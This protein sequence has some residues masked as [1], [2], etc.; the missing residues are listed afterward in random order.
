MI[1]DHGR[2]ARKR[3]SQGA[4]GVRVAVT[5]A[6]ACVFR[7]PAMEAALAANFTPEAV[8]AVSIPATG[9]NSDLHATAEYRA[10]M[11]TV[12]AAR[13]VAALQGDV[14][15]GD[16]HLK[17]VAAPALRHRLRRNALDDAGSSVRVERAMSE[18]FAV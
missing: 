11:V 7:V 12:M 1:S 18:V 15:V 3:L 17:Q 6:G 4:G 14:E 9:L 2:G 10:A 5:G 16:A 8:K 13:A